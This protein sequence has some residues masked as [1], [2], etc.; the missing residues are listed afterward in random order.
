MKQ[1]LNKMISGEPGVSSKRVIT[2]VAAGLVFFIAIV[3]LFTDKTITD[4]V[5]QGVAFIAMAGLGSI[6][7][8]NF[9]NSNK[10]GTPTPVK[11][12]KKKTPDEDLPN[13]IDL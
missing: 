3:D 11:T 4:Y 9:A 8:E 13:N 10:N 1:F 2:T 5:F 7:L 12:N 6:A